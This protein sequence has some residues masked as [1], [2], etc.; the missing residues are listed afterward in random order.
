MTTGKVAIG[1]ILAFAAAAFVMYL[2][3]PRSVPATP[4]EIVQGILSVPG[5]CREITRTRVMVQIATNGTMSRR[6][7]EMALA[8][9]CETSGEQ[10]EAAALM[11]Q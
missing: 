10:Y 5:K 1:L 9:G 11:R 8:K 3:I 7:L 2:A 6:Q 4:R